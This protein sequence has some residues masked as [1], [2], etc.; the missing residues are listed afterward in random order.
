MAINLWLCHFER[1]RN[2]AYIVAAVL[3]GLAFWYVMGNHCITEATRVSSITRRD[4]VK[5]KTGHREIQIKP[6]GLKCG[7]YPG[8]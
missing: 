4:L 7:Q 8:V 5:N 6:L 1:M 3:I 2:A